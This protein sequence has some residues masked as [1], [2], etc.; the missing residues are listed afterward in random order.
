MKIGILGYR[1][2][3]GQLLV[4]ALQSDSWPGLELAGGT[5]RLPEDSTEF[6]VTNR[7]EA[8]FERADCVIDFTQPEA[9]RIHLDLAQKT[10]TTMV[11]GTTG[12][13]EEDKALITKTAQHV[14]IVF[15]PNMSVGVNF[16]L[17]LVEQTA[18][19]LAKEWDIEI[20]EIHHRHKVDAPSGT[21]LALGEAAAKGRK[22]ILDEKAVF[23]RHGRHEARK[24]GDIGFS[25]QAGGD[26][27]GE[28][29][30]TFFGEGERIEL[31]H[32][33]HNRSLFAKGA[34]KAAQWLDGKPAELYSMK[35]V[36]GLSS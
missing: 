36:L 14:P 31:T 3:V 20:N 34:L 24:Q 15:A 1:G 26:V 16:L 5:S 32:K 4:Q 25:V 11:I 27:C 9:T 13:S 35:D 8:L 7:P 18:A 2:R 12:L 19:K 22:V 10:G 33:A 6:F 21:A 23:T 17:T 28:H 30:V 29:T